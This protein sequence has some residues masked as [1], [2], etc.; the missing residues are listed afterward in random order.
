M[1]CDI[2]RA[3]CD[4]LLRGGQ[5]RGQNRGTMPAEKEQIQ[6]Q[7]EGKQINK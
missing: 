3:A 6:R 2:H 7:G 1:S 5:L 4:R